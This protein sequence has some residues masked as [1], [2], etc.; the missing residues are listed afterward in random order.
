VK[1]G[2][3]TS[4]N[5]R[6]FKVIRRLAQKYPKNGKTKTTQPRKLAPVDK[7]EIVAACWRK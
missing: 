4:N 1:R 7:R 5:L 2:V 3:D 6:M